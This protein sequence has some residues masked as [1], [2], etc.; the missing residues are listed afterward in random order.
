MFSLSERHRYYLYNG[1]ADMRK[2]F[3][4]LSGLVRNELGMDPLTGDVYIFMNRNRNRMKMLVWE[5]GGFVLY[6]KRLEQGRFSKGKVR[7]G[8]LSI[9]YTW[10]DLMLLVGG[11]E[12]SSIKKR[13][14]FSL[15]KQPNKKQKK[16][17]KKEVEL[18]DFL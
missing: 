10:Q 2:G 16:V 3:D 11:I 12:V 13:K 8:Q 17:D 6:Y 1:S 14:R 9:E 18:L 4:G 7:E 15:K 5:Q